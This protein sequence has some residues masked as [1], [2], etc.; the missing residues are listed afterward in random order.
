MGSRIGAALCVSLACIASCVSTSPRERALDEASTRDLQQ[1]LTEL[2][3]GVHAL[4]E[5][6]RESDAERLERVAAD[7]EREL[8]S[9]ETEGA[10]SA[11]ETDKLREWQR[12]REASATVKEDANKAHARARLDVLRLRIAE[13]EDRIARLRASLHED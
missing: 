8:L 10:M 11:R 4:E 7:V 6:E 2:R 1:I 9:R 5:L 12:V 13:V 3:Q